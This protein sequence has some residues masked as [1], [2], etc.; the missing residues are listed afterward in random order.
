VLLHEHL[1]I[2]NDLN[3]M[4]ALFAQRA[5]VD[6]GFI[7]FQRLALRPMFTIIQHFNYYDYSYIFTRLR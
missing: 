2:C 1:I 7:V 6:L 4:W 3:V 5:S